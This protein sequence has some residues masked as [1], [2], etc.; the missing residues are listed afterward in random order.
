MRITI[1]QRLELLDYLLENTRI[2][3]KFAETLAYRDEEAEKYFSLIEQLKDK[4]DKTNLLLD[5]PV[6]DLDLSVRAKNCLQRTGIMTLGDILFWSKMKLRCIRSLGNKCLHEI[7]EECR[8]YG[9]E[10]AEY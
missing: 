1:E 6:S 5:L 2:N 7:V 4:N 8:E 3:E 9:F 10:L